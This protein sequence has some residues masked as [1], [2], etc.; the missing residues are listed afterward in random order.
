[1]ASLFY[2]DEPDGLQGVQAGDI[3][4]L[5]GSEARHA[6]V[7]R[8]RPGETV[9]IGDG[10]GTVATG[11]VERILPDRLEMRAEKVSHTDRAEPRIALAQALA[12]GGR[13]ELAVQAATELGVD[14]VV[15]WGAKRS[16]PRWTGAKRERG[17]AR[18]HA[19]AREAGKQSL[20]AWVPEVLP[21]H[22]CEGLTTWTGEWQVVVLDP[23]CTLGLA[24][25]LGVRGA[26]PMP[27]VTPFDATRDTLLAVGPEG[28]FDPD[29]LRAF[30]LAGAVRVRLGGSVLRTST[31]GPAAIAVLAAC[32][33]GRW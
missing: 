9:S 26:A 22:S 20:R 18:W 4:T 23:G 28:G 5:T 24:S 30:S 14:V 33:L 2:L 1:M 7:N 3:C 27:G 29:E 25:W 17:L 31:A 15:P 32:G 13:D 10:I 12:K 6:A 19:V 21:L 16:V 8:L 11:R